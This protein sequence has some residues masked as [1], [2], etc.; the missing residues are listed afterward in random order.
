MCNLPVHDI[1]HITP[2]VSGISGGLATIAVTIR[3]VLAIGD[4][5]IDDL[6]III[7]LVV[8]ALP[9]GIL[10][11]FTSADGFGRDMWT[12]EPEKLYRIIQVRNWY[13]FIL[14]YDDL[15]H[16]S[17]PGWAKSFTFQRLPSLRLLFS[18]SAYV[19]SHARKSG[20]S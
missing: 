5:Y 16:C 6:F 10:E 4:F 3:T 19:S 14:G 7:A 18:S 1:T 20:G 11:F 13:I 8:G 2:I 17:L 12:V 15:I 9:M